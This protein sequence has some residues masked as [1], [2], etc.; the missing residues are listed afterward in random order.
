MTKGT[1]AMDELLAARQA[2]LEL[3]ASWYHDQRESDSWRIPLVD[4]VSELGLEIARF[5]P[6]DYAG[7]LGFLD[8]DDNL[9][10]LRADLTPESERFTLAHELGHWRLHRQSGDCA[11][12]DLASGAVLRPEEAYSPRGQRERE[13]NAFAGELLVPSARLRAAYL[14]DATASREDDGVD[15]TGKLTTPAALARACGVSVDVITHQLI[16]LLLTTEPTTHNRPSIPPNGAPN[17]DASQAEAVRVPAPALIVAGPGTGKTSTL[18]GRVQWLVEQGVAPA[19]ILALTYSRKAAREMRDRI[20]SALD[21]DTTLPT[22]ATFHRFGADVLRMYAPRVGLRP[23]FTLIDEI[24]AFFL[25]REV[26]A[27]LPLDRYLVLSDPT[28]HFSTLLQAISRAKDELLSPEDYAARAEEIAAQVTTPE[29]QEVAELYREIA[30]VYQAYQ[31]ELRRRGDADFGDMIRLVVTL[32]R[33]QPTIRDQLRDQYQHVL[34]DEFQDINRANGV[35]LREL[36][37]PAGNIWA[38]GDANQAIYRFRGASPANINQFTTDYPAAQIVALRYNYR[39]RPAIV[40]IA[41]RFAA[42][43]LEPLTAETPSVSPQVALQPVR[44]PG[45]DP[46]ALWVA[47]DASSEISAIA[48]D[49]AHRIAD[50]APPSTIAVLCR[51]RQ[52][53]RQLAAALRTI[54]IPA[55]TRT[56]LFDDDA[57]RTILGVPHLM[58]GASAGF[59]W[60]ARLKSFAISDPTLHLVLAATRAEGGNPSEGLRTTLEQTDLSAEDRA[61]LRRLRETMQELRVAP[62]ITAGLVRY[63]FAATAIG[64]TALGG[65]DEEALPGVDS[66]TGRAGVTLRDHLAELFL[67]ARRFDEEQSGGLSAARE[68]PDGQALH[69]RAFLSYLRIVRTLGR[70]SG[71]GDHVS[72][73]GA[74]G[75]A[76]L[77]VHGAKGLEWPTVYLPFL[78]TRRFPMQRQAEGAPPPPGTGPSGGTV[79]LA[80]LS[81]EACLFY[82]AITRAR[83]TLILSRAERYSAKQRSGPSQFLEPLREDIALRNV[84]LPVVEAQLLAE[85]VSSGDPLA[86]VQPPVTEDSLLSSTALDTY[87]RCPRQYALRYSLGL[88]GEPSG[89]G[90]LRQVVAQTLR[91]AAQSNEATSDALARF[92]RLWQVAL[93]AGQ[94]DPFDPLYQRL[95]VSAIER[96][97]QSSEWAAVGSLPSLRD[98]PTADHADETILP[99]ANGN[100]SLRIDRVA[101]LQDTSTGEPRFVAIRHRLGRRPRHPKPDLRQYLLVQAQRILSGDPTADTIYEHQLDADALIPVT[102]S[103]TEERKLHDHLHDLVEGLRAGEFP[104]R[105]DPQRCA[106]CA[107]VLLCTRQ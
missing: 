72:P 96:S 8:P 52:Q 12:E 39:S 63:C 54:A 51:T 40:A 29:E 99:I 13:A 83:D 55:E 10:W 82:V 25:L 17:L 70:D 34:V 75:V 91:E 106:Q 46:L 88:N 45:P 48:T 57:I 22:V 107:F 47:P 105:P 104:V 93:Q 89:Y 95:G 30:A 92:E 90:R 76:L 5:S 49:I 102:L 50:G 81:E 28:R 14:D 42:R 36:V 3:R 18:V 79:A 15:R 21:T 74:S 68:H 61:A 19:R 6:A 1:A 24:G 20:A 41:N 97:A 7:T 33:T 69:W 101:S 2:A 35:L 73:N 58:A 11:A 64:K 67:L 80:H 37:G 87:D 9:I 4:L 66:T 86:D 85:D 62:T 26:A 56:D 103:A 94:P 43:I 16:Q 60:A 84:T 44:P 100:V 32:L 71:V 98:G 31:A 53:T 65:V 77:T 38:V 23:D 59:L 27:S 78:A